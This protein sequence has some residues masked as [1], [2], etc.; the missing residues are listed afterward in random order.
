MPL[1]HTQWILTILITHF[2]GQPRNLLQSPIARLWT[3][4]VQILG[5]I[6]SEHPFQSEV[7]VGMHV[8]EGVCLFDNNKASDKKLPNIVIVVI[9]L[10]SCTHIPFLQAS[11]V[12]IPATPTSALQSNSIVKTLESPVPH[13]N[14]LDAC[15]GS[16]GSS[17]VVW[18]YGDSHKLLKGRGSLILLLQTHQQ[19]GS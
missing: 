3:K 10:S 16:Q 17:A 14:N 1:V 13:L 11:A 9:T 18:S 7:M 19:T 2:S 8:N 6:L 15:H 12:S 4:Q 5:I